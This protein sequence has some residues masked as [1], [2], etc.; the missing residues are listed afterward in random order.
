MIEVARTRRPLYCIVG[1]K[2]KWLHVYINETSSER[3]RGLKT[4]E[5]K[6]GGS[7]YIYKRKKA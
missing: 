4:M 3:G 7:V 1:M 2:M 6:V 5:E